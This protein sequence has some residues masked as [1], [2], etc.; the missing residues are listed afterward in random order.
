[1]KKFRRLAIITAA[2]VMAVSMSACGRTKEL[3]EQAQNNAK[4]A[5]ESLKQM[6]D[7]MAEMEAEELIGT[8]ESNKIDLTE[9]F[10]QGVDESMKQGFGTTI[11]LADYIDDFTVICNLTFNG[12]GTY[13]TSL[14]AAIEGDSFREGYTEYIR[15][16]F[17]EKEGK[18]LTDAEILEKY[19]VDMSTFADDELSNEALSEMFAE[20]S[21]HGNFTFDGTNLSLDENVTGTY[22]DG[23]ITM[24]Y[25]EIGVLTFEK[26]D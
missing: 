16:V 4:I 24:D 3:V 10:A 21:V 7:A 20:D 6:E 11:S 8:W 12:D 26:V 22:E 23:V 9:Y 5:E 2:A 25:G 19:E 14:S 1:M 18:E 17:N 13:D 15:D